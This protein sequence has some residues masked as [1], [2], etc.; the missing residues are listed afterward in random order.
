MESVLQLGLIVIIMILIVA[1]IFHSSSI[2]PWFI[3]TN[4]SPIT[5]STGPP[6][7]VFGTLVVTF[8]IYLIPS[9]IINADISVAYPLVCGPFFDNQKQLSFSHNAIGWGV[10]ALD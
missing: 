10:G 5:V 6:A 7:L 2:A 4:P 9:A 3:F 1:S 8:F